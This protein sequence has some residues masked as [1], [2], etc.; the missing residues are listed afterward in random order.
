MTTMTVT[1]KDMQQRLPELLSQVSGGKTIIIEKNKK[2][3]A[4]LVAI[5][6][7]SKKRIAG[8]NRGEIL[9]SDDFD[10]LLPDEFWLAEK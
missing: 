6:F 10:A 3:L 9:V 8:L 4:R 5:D 1:V 7:N 2:P